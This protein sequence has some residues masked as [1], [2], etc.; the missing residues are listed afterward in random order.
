VATFA[1]RE[2]TQQYLELVRE[3][4]FISDEKCRKLLA[5]TAEVESLIS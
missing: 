1:R 3:G 2:L 5:D 4:P